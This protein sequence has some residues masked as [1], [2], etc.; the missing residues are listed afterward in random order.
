MLWLQVGNTSWKKIQ[1][2]LWR[3]QIFVIFNDWQDTL[4]SVDEI[5][6]QLFPIIRVFNQRIAEIFNIEVGGFILQL[7]FKK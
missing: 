7:F 2:N 1:S 6:S 4:Q 5:I 3:K